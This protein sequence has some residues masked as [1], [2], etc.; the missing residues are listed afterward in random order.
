MKILVMNRGSSSIK[1]SFYDFPN[2]IWESKVDSTAL[3]LSKLKSVKPDAI[4]HRVVHGGKRFQ[5]ALINARLKREINHYAKFAPLHNKSDLEA[6]RKL[7]KLFPKVPQVAVFD[8]AFHHTLSAAAFTYPGPYSW[9]K[10]GIRRYGFHGISFQY[11]TRHVAEKLGAMPKKMVICHLGAGAS[12]CAVLNGKSVDTTMGFTPLEGLMMDTR[13]GTVD[14]G[15]LLYLFSKKTQK[16]LTKELYENS[17]LLGLSGISSDM[18][19]LLNSKSARAKLALDVYIH[20]LVSM[21][22]SMIATL[23]GIDTL[24]FTG[25]IG[26]NA[27]VIRE[28][29]CDQLSFLKMKIVIVHTQ[30]AFEIARETA[31]I[32]S[33]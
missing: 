18:R 20:R 32:L 1:M 15:I 10:A 3:D 28:R 11:C 33:R 6:I 2:L 9:L 30:E 12:L 29:V 23:G 17:G 14:P 26:E 8:T 4:G 31:I 24:V 5:S 27:A 13:S 22:G 19:D 25:G 7:E 21:I 16:Q